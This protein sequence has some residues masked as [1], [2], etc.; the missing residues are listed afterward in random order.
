[1]V[2]ELGLFYQRGIN[3]MK[4]PIS[5]IEILICAV[6]CLVS[7]L[8]IF[9]TIMDFSTCTKWETQMVEKTECITLDDDLTTCTTSIVPEEVCV[10]RE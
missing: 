7:F 8:I 4:R 9:M 6:I 10:S 3:I 2:V 1:M 5:P